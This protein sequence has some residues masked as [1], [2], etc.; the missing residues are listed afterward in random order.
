MNFDNRRW[1]EDEKLRDKGVPLPKEDNSADEDDDEKCR[2][3]GSSSWIDLSDSEPDAY[4]CGKCGCKFAVQN[5]SRYLNQEIN[6]LRIKRAKQE[7]WGITKWQKA[8]TVIFFGITGFW[9][10]SIIFKFL[11]G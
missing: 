11:V 5:P 10:F 7:F 2:Y 8:Q 6:H 4:W 9:A 1:D 3:C